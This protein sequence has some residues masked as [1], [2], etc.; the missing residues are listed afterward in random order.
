MAPIITAI[1]PVIPVL[2]DAFK[3][4]RKLK[5]LTLET[6]AAQGGIVA[7]SSMLYAGIA[8]SCSE[9][10]DASCLLDVNVALYVSLF[11]SLFWL[12]KRAVAKGKGE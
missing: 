6:Q 2:W 9:G 1:I 12:A 4:K 7:A 8:D 5:E 10:F 3:G 11:T